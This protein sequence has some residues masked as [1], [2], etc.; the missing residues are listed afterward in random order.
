MSL[1]LFEV[2]LPSHFLIQHFPFPLGPR[3]TSIF[4]FS[5]SVCCLHFFTLSLYCQFLLPVTCSCLLN[6]KPFFKPITHWEYHLVLPPPPLPGILF[7][8]SVFTSFASHWS[9]TS[10]IYASTPN[11]QI[12]LDLTCFW[13]DTVDTLFYVKLPA[14]SVPG[15]C[16]SHGISP[17]F[18]TIPCQPFVCV[19]KGWWS[20]GLSLG[21]LLSSH[22]SFSHCSPCVPSLKLSSQ[23]R[24]MSS[25]SMEQYPAAHWLSPQGSPGSPD[26]SSLTLDFSS[27]FC[28]FISLLVILIL[29]LTSPLKRFPEI[30]RVLCV[31]YT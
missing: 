19:Q 26:A 10:P 15:T 25:Q 18:L 28:T 20:I 8:R 7:T 14:L 5:L 17:T 4:F 6:L 30:T 12:S 1:L 16:F 22:C 23:V 21:R 31:F 9:S 29:V 3:T 11:R 24:V 2:Y 27:S 13:I